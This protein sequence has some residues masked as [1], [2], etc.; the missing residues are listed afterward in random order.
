MQRIGLHSGPTTAGVLRGIKGRFQLFADTVN[1]A[2]RMESTGTP[3][4]IQVSQATADELIRLGKSH[5]LSARPDLVQAKGKGD[6]QTYYVT[7]DVAK[8]CT[9][10]HSGPSKE[11]SGLLQHSSGHSARSKLPDIQDVSEASGSS[12][13]SD[14]PDHDDYNDGDNHGDNDSDNNNTSLEDQLKGYLSR[15]HKSK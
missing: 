1:T 3:G 7:P 12:H 10:R 4:R 15:N 11:S 5:W 2:S 6:L 9:T 8:S 13:D 14:H